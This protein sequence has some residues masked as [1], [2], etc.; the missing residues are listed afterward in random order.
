MVFA[1]RYG[2][3]FS[4]YNPNFDHEKDSDENKAACIKRNLFLSVPFFDGGSSRGA[5]R[6]HGRT[7]S[8]RARRAAALDE[9]RAGNERIGSDGRGGDISGGHRADR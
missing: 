3:A 4:F 7:G 1:A 8:E 2:F 9:K 5:A 6:V